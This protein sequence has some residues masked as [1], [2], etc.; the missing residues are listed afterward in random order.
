MKFLQYICLTILFLTLSSCHVGRFFYWNFADTDDLNKFE[1]V[2]IKKGS[3][4]FYFKEFTEGQE[5]FVPKTITYKKKTAVPFEE[6]LEKSGTT[7]FIVLKDDQLLYEKY[8]KDYTKATE[9]PS[10]SVSKS[11]ISALIGIATVSYTHL[12]LPTIYS[13]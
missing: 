13:V 6:A 2:P 7:A 1:S 4:S 12:T 9:H 5:K 11:F 8:F 10:F 3:T